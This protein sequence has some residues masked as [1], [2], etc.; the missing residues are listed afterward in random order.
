MNPYHRELHIICT[1]VLL[2]VDGICLSTYI[3]KLKTPGKALCILC[4]SDINYANAG[5]KALQMHVSSKKHKTKAA[6]QLY[7]CWCVCSGVRTTRGR[8]KENYT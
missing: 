5:A 1:D 4:S 3:R 2:Q 7:S 8:K 6:D